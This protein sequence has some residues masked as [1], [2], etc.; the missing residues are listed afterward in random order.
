[1]VLNAFSKTAQLCSGHVLPN[2]ED[3]DSEGVWNN[4][5]QA[6]NLTN[7][8]YTG[9]TTITPTAEGVYTFALTCGG[10]QSGFASL[11]V[12]GNSPLKIQTTS[13]HQATVSQPYTVI[14]SATG[15]MSP[16]F[17]AEVGTLPKGL[18]F[19]SG[20]GTLSGTPLQ[21]GDYPLGFGVQ[22]S[23]VPPLMNAV[24]LSMNVESGL[25]LSSALPQPTVGKPYSQ[26][27]MTTGGL[28]PYQYTLVSGN[29]PPGLNFN[30]TAG[31]VSGTPTESGTYSVAIQASDS[32]NPKAMVSQ[33]IGL[34]TIGPLKVIT[35]ALLPTGLTGV[36]YTTSL[37]ATGGTP[38]YSWTVATAV[39]PYNQIPPGLAL[40]S[41]GTIA[42]TPIQFA[43]PSYQFNVTVTDSEN[44]KVSVTTQMSLRVNSNLKIT[45]DSLPNGTV[46]VETNVPLTATGGIP[47]YV[48][49]ASSN[50][51][52]SIIGIY[53]DGDVL[54]LDPIIATTAIVTL[55]VED[56]EG[57]YAQAQVT[58][59]LTYLPAPLATSTTL[60]SSNTAAGTGE[61]VTL[62]ATVAVPGGGTPIG[63]V[64]FY[65][66]AASIGTANLNASG[67]ATLQTSFATPGVYSITAAYGG[68]ASYGV[69]TSS[70]VTETVV[71]PT[72]S[73]AVAPAS[74]T[75]APGGFGKLVITLTPTGDYA[76]TVNFSC[77]TL[78][79]HVSCTFAPSSLTIAAG[80]GPFTDTLTVSTDEPMTAI[81]R[82]PGDRGSH[83]GLFAA[84]AFWLPGSLAAML[85]MVR[86]KRRRAG[87]RQR[88]LLRK[89]WIIVL[90]GVVFGGALSSCG[91]SSNDAQAGTYKIPIT[92]TLKGA[93][94][95]DI[96]ATVIVE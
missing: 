71:T 48:W 67:Q 17:W 84:T 3:A 95:Q 46:G 33:T 61:S 37:A 29:L 26:A 36:A 78:P 34:S 50:P 75:I 57:T 60:A 7:G 55:V 49:F 2:P 94:K 53:I 41:S 44:P 83:N 38:P 47:P 23:S 69:S 6:G 51:K 35:P 86:R 54:E 45:V 85:G 39:P 24:S 87:P 59:P 92:L 62:S 43:G 31:V 89:L 63:P 16:Y 8:V 79:A 77:G 82:Q 5:V 66:G 40:S 70:P 65:N 96:S 11:V 21:Y 72:I 13:L 1:M 30:T 52:P 15:G 76:G 90:L 25:Q 19:N 93:T 80:S 9:S 22:D 27:L 73:A 56:S 28:P 88:N 74:L 91:G 68:N 10:L 18:T 4:E 42:G 14:L 64:I 20:T 81:L 58:L 12:T 32:E